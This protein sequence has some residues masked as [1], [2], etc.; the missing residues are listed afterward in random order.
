M[1]AAEDVYLVA[2]GRPPLGDKP[3]VLEASGGGPTMTGSQ[4]ASV[5]NTIRAG[6]AT[7]HKAIGD[8]KIEACMSALSRKTSTGIFGGAF[9]K[10]APSLVDDTRASLAKDYKVKDINLKGNLGFSAGSELEGGVENTTPEGTE[11]GL[12]NPLANDIRG[13]ANPKARA[14]KV[15]DALAI[16]ARRSAFLAIA[17]KDKPT[18]KELHGATT[19]AAF[20]K[21]S[22][23][24][25]KVN[26][27]AVTYDLESVLTVL[28]GYIKSKAAKQS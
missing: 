11:I 19:T 8:F 9:V 17:D 23:E 1:G 18:L 16:I 20:L 5:F 7:E 28:V 10:Q 15:A 21:T 24:G 12:L 22:F 14:P 13:L 6:L 27:K 26:P 3:A 2:H 4:V 25:L